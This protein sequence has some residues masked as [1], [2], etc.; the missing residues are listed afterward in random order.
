MSEL[1][2][3]KLLSYFS[4]EKTGGVLVLIAGIIAVV[5]S[6]ILYRNSEIYRGVAY[7]LVLIALAEIGLGIGLYLRTDKQVAI[8]QSTYTNSVSDFK[9]IEIP[10]MEK[11]MTTFKIVKLSEVALLI[12]SL[13]LSFLYLKNNLIYSISIG[14]AIQAGFLFIFDLFAEKR[15]HEY[16]EFIKGI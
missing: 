8:L 10:R 9:N 5:A 14:I 2:Q 7:P 4:Q 6:V 12:I 15:A 3:I 1:F 11:V 13:I 16:L